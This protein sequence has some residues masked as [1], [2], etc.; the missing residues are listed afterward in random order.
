MLTESVFFNYE[1]LKLFLKI[2]VQQTLS[3]L[4]GFFGEENRVCQILW[5]LL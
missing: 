3:P 5:F 2:I 4:F 1:E